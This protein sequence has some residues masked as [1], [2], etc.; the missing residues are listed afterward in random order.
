[1][2]QQA[3]VKLIGCETGQVVYVNAG[4]AGGTVYQFYDD[5]L[6]LIV[7]VSDPTN[8]SETNYIVSS[9]C[10]SVDPNEDCKTC[11][12]NSIVLDTNPE[13]GLP[14][15]VSATGLNQ[16]PTVEIAYVLVNCGVDITF[17]NP[18]DIDQSPQGAL[19]TSTDLSFYV[20]SVVNIEEYPDYCYYVMGPFDTNTGCPCTRYTVTQAFKD[21]K[22][23]LPEL[24][25][26]FVRIIPDPVKRFY[27]ID[28]SECNIRVN[29]KFSEGYYKLF[30]GLAYGIENCCANL[31]LDLLWIQKELEDYSQIFDPSAC[32]VPVESTVILCPS[33]EK[34]LAPTTV[35]AQGSFIYD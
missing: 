7:S 29:T 24:P 11:F 3:C 2:N 5:Q 35:S 12:E 20:G 6:E 32:V 16:C 28:D 19:V 26:K 8:F 4:T 9:I 25:K 34:C 33:D 30:K 17:D 22:C 27:H 15:N 1:M 10:F 23:C 21:C 14:Q 31:D 18:E 13:T